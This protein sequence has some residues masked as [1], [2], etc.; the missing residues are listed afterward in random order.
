MEPAKTPVLKD[1]RFWLA[2][3][4]ALSL[5]LS[6]AF[7][8]NLSAETLAAI[9]TLVV[10]TIGASAAKEAKVSSAQAAAVAAAAASPQMPPSQ[11]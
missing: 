6:D 3:C 5:A 9:V 10:T 7:G 8:V 11:K 4:T 1:K 2:V